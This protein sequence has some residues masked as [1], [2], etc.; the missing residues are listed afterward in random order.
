MVSESL[1][2][3]PGSGLKPPYSEQKALGQK[4]EHSVDNLR[5]LF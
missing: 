1:A 2:Q 4:D 3:M 5:I